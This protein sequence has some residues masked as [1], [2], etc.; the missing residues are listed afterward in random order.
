VLLRELTR[1]TDSYVVCWRGGQPTLCDTNAKDG[2][3]GTRL[4]LRGLP[5]A[6]VGARGVGDD[7]EP[8][9]V[10][11]FGFVFHDFG[12]EA[13]GLFGCGFDVVNEDVGEPGGGSSWDG[14]L[15]HAAAGTTF[16]FE[17]GVTHA[18]AHIV[19]CELPVKERGVEG[20]GF[21]DVGGVELEMTEGI[22]HCGSFKLN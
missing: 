8:A 21:V 2:P 9:H 18:T 13:C 3:P 1:L 4:L 7:G 22:V 19:V 14:V 17:G 12:A 5:E 15:H 20:F 11:D 10:R 16:G 6:E